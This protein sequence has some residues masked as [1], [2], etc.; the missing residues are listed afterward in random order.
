[1]R[2]NLLGE[3]QTMLSSPPLNCS[4]NIVYDDVEKAE[5]FNTF[6]RL[7][8][9]LMILTNQ[10]QLT[11]HRHWDIWIVLFFGNMK[12]KMYWDF[13]ILTRHR[14]QMLFMPNCYKWHTI[15]FLN[16]CVLFLTLVWQ[17][18]IFQINGNWQTLPLSTKKR[19]KT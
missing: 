4:N 3:T 5:A 2:H 11:I 9:I 12:F 7:N 19:I 13:L 18:S 14:G 10:Y 1:M 16:H 6:F 17:L 8:Q 15:L